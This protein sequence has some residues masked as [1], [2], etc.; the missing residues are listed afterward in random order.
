MGDNFFAIFTEDHTLVHIEITNI[1]T[2]EPEIMDYYETR[3]VAEK[4]LALI[5][6]LV[7]HK[8]A[9]VREVSES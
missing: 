4:A 6:E 5:P 9:H 1:E 8:G 3:E 2:D 7:K